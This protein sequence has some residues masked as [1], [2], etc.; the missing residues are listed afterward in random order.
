VSELLYLDTARLGRLSPGAAAAL[1]DFV[2]LASDEGAGLYFDRFLSTGLTTCPKPFASRYQG[3][4]VWHG[5]GELKR[6]LR[7]LVDGQSELPTLLA[8]RSAS[9]VRF[10]G[11]LLFHPCRNVLVTDLDWPPWAAVV[12]AEAARAG[13]T[14]TQVAV[15]DAALAGDLSADDLAD[16]VCLQFSR[17]G[18]DGL[19][20]TAVS[21]LGIRTPVSQIVAR[22]EATHHVRSVVVDGAQEFCQVRPSEA[23]GHCDFYLAGSHKWLGGYQPLGIGFYGRPRS[24][25]RVETILGEMLAAGELDDPL[26]RFC[27]MLE[28]GARAPVVETVNIASLFAAQG[29][30]IDAAAVS[31]RL[32]ARIENA[33]RAA[34][35]I[36]G[37]GWESLSPH[38]DLAS[39]IL[40]VRPE[41]RF[42]RHR[43]PEEVRAALRDAGVAATVYGGGTVRLSMPGSPWRSD[44]LRQLCNSLAAVA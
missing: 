33:R 22:L 26:L 3:L 13:R 30:A 20:L 38:P 10:A 32:E 28:T 41:R 27:S 43:D 16:I 25:G 24:R 5:V 35:S 4:S 12:A 1:R 42:V 18:C 31:L 21:N 9:L 29:A 11:R 34:E 6:S 19:Y 36:G 17:S 23:V 39:G 37:V 44:Q 8:T 15:R 7:S 40:L 2:A 14:L